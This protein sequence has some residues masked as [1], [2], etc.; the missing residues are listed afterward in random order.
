MRYLN[1]LHCRVD[2]ERFYIYALTTGFMLLS[3]TQEQN[4]DGVI[5]FS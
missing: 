5:F 2:N 1:W 4:Y 3:Y